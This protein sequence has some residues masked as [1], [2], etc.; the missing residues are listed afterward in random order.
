MKTKVRLRALS[1]AQPWA[2]CIVAHGK[3]VENRGWDTSKRGYVAIHASRS[4]E[5]SR[6]EAA[7]EEYGLRFDP[8]E[9]DYGALVGFAE[10]VEVITEAD[11]TAKTQKWFVGHFGFVL[12]GVIRLKKSIGVKGALSFWLMP[13]AV[14]NK[15]LAQLS[16]AQR[17]RVLHG[18]LF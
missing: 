5:V 10:I 15:A 18:A 2:E 7:E 12:R 9:M 4:R 3:N 16:K 8:D 11:V 13:M 14:Q 6:F 1:V 17:E